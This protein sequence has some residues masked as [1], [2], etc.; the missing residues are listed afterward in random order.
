M[1]SQMTDKQP[2]A[3]APVWAGEVQPVEVAPAAVPVAKSSKVK[4][5]V[6]GVVAALVIG[7]GG[8]AVIKAAGGASAGA[9]AQQGGPGGNGQGGPGGMGN[10]GGGGMGAGAGLSGALYGDFTASDGNGGYATKRL[11]T[12]TVTAISATSITAKSADGHATTFVINGSTSV[13]NGNDQ[14][15]DVKTGDTVTVVGT[16]SGDT[17][18]ATAINDSTLNQGGGG[19]QGQQNG[20]PAN[21]ATN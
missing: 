3:A 12:G 1:S 9:T 8:F 10:F 20:P 4:T 14:V 15:A 7:G 18:T 21:G 5:V 17:A 11:Q 16:V 2:P 19:P 6:V 13:D